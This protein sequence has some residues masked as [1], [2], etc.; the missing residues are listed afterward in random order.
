MAVRIFLAISTLIWLPYGVY[1]FVH[2]GY[3]GQA[4]GVM[5]LTATGTTE[6]RA[7]YGGLQAGI[8][9]LTL[10]GLLHDAFRRQALVMLAF[11]CGGLCSSRIAGAFLDGSFSSYTAYALVFEIG[12][13]AAAIW[14]LRRTEPAS[15]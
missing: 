2:P 5:S 13:T 12:S 6:I 10:A 11:L 14:L 15:A 3:L 4:A 7:M 8:G 1:C 9:L